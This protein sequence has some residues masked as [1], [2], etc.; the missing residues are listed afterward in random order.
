MSNVAIKF[1]QKLLFNFISNIANSETAVVCISEM[2]GKSLTKVATLILHMIDRCILCSCNFKFASVYAW[3]P[4]Q[5]SL[6]TLITK[7]Q[8]RAQFTYEFLRLSVGIKWS[9]IKESISCLAQTSQWTIIMRCALLLPSAAL[10][11]LL[12]SS[13]PTISEATIAIAVASGTTTLLSL[14]AAQVRKG[15]CGQF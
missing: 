8:R 4:T 10:V 1:I 6:V 11:V 9:L 15:H 14:T 12:L 2:F 5:T 7:P 13:L 3:K